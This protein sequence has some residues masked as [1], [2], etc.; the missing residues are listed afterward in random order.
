MEATKICTFQEPVNGIE[1]ELWMVPFK[2]LEES[3]YQRAFSKTLANKLSASVVKG[4][5]MPLIVVLE[6]GKWKIIDGQHRKA[7]VLKAKGAVLI[8]CIKV[9]ERFKYYTLLYNIEKSDAIKDRC[10][11]AF[12]LYDDFV[13]LFPEKTEDDLREYVNNEPHLITLA[14]AYKEHGLRSP[15]LIETS[16]KKFDHFLGNLKLPMSME[17][18]QHRGHLAAL[19]EK[20]VYETADEYGV[21]DY[22]LKQAMV[23]KTN[24]QLWDKK[25]NVDEPF[26]DAVEQMIDFIENKDWGFLGRG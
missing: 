5:F 19:L 13:H 17:T 16:L 23:S 15:S 24:A 21:T 18:R 9:P 1:C 20:A 12:H 25:R 11:K 6:N 22:I 3:E 2:E 14:F 26:D 10:T 7:A 8:P 4:F